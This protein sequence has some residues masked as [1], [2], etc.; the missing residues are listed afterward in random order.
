MPNTLLRGQLLKDGGEGF[1]YEVQRHPELLMKIYKARDAAGDAIVTPE[2]VS[3]LRHM[4]EHPPKTLVAQGLIAWPTELLYEDGEFIGFVMPRLR[5][6]AQI[7]SAYSYRHPVIDASEY[8]AYPSVRSRVGVAVNL[9]SALHEL[10]KAGYVV[11]DL[12]HENIGIN[13]ATGQVYFVDC[14][15]FHL[16][17][18]DGI[19]YRTNVIMGGYL[20]PEIIAHC[21]DERAAGRP[22]MLDKVALPTFTQA[23]DLFCLAIHIFKLL[24]NGVDPFRGVNVATTGS[25]ASPFLGNDAIERNAYVFREGNRPSAVFCPPAASL[26]PELLALFEHAFVVGRA[27]PSARP[28][29]ETWYNALKAH[30]N[31]LTQCAR[32]GKHFYGSHLTACPHCAADEAYYAL[33][34]GATNAMPHVAAAVVEPHMKR[35]TVRSTSESPW[36]HPSMPKPPEPEKKSK[37]WVAV[38]AVILA[39]A[40][41]I[42]V[43]TDN[44]YYKRLGYYDNNYYNVL[45]VGGEPE[46]L[47][48]NAVEPMFNQDDVYCYLDIS[49]GNVLSATEYGWNTW[50]LTATHAG[51]GS[52][53]LRSYYTDVSYSETWYAAQWIPA[54]F[55]M[56]RGKVS[57]I[58]DYLDDGGA[59]YGAF[60]GKLYN[61]ATKLSPL[62]TFESNN[63]YVVKISQDTGSIT[64]VGGGG[65]TITVRQGGNV[66]QTYDV[67]VAVLG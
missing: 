43:Y 20:A 13:Y 50:E 1:I 14:D 21:N 12:N 28:T 61:M 37:K 66:L 17:G 59:L 29:S 35:Q 33:Q 6:D 53:G 54:S 58:F 44:R 3:K 34:R 31:S 16:T 26:P 48:L 11:G 27:N 18:G 46:H 9:C 5:F 32:D 4:S 62:L 42:G 55:Y 39:I 40:L 52:F 65:A 64:A 38:L 47:T 23:S 63:E 8:G 2:L 10:H 56:N 49:G 24:M 45:F 30:Y 19:I 22:Y 57:N 41:A 7:Q 60:G 67:V 51:S 15:S 36:G 25:A